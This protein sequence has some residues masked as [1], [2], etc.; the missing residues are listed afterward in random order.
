MEYDLTPTSFDVT[1]FDSGHRKKKKLQ[2]FSWF[3]MRI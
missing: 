1:A 2:L 3:K